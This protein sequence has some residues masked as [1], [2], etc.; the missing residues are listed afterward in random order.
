MQ[1]EAH[2]KELEV[3]S[4]QSELKFKRD[5]TLFQEKVIPLIEYERSSFENEITL[6]ILNGFKKD[7]IARWQFEITKIISEST[8]LI[9][10]INKKDFAMSHYIIKAPITGHITN[11]TGITQNSNIL[12]GQILAEISPHINLIIECIIR[13]ENIGF[14]HKN[15]RV[16]FNMDAFNHNQWGSL[17]G[18]VLEID[19]NP[20]VLNK[21]MV[22]MVRCRYLNQDL[23][24]KNGLKGKISKGMTLTGNFFLV[25]RRI[26]DLLFDRVDNW[27]NPSTLNAI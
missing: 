6:E 27:L 10:E 5:Q 19:Q 21:Q 1:Y 26:L 7:N 16:Q 24:M 9:Q 13:P 17:K 11:F 14:I 18:I 4:K 12:S 20:K 22:F 8:S 23:M 3:K 15:Q 25:K 2:L